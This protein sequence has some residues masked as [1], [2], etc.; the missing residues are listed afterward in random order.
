[1]QVDFDREP[2]VEDHLYRRIQIAVVLRSAIR[3][4][5]RV[6]HRLRIHA[7]AD[8][9]KSGGL[10][11]RDVRGCCPVLEMFFRISARVVHLGKPLAQVD[12]VPNMR[13][14]RSGN[15]RSWKGLSK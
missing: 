7:Q 13:E 4:S 3:L 12:S 10:D 11:E 2:S 8:V 14:S 15:S 1:M 9:V 5:R 6:Q